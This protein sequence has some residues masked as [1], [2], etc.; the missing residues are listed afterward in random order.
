[1]ASG[2][3][4]T[5]LPMRNCGLLQRTPSSLTRP[6]RATVPHLMEGDFNNDNMMVLHIA[7]RI[8]ETWNRTGS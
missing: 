8:N 7:P 1:M 4:D 2:F 5:V 3:P 6:E